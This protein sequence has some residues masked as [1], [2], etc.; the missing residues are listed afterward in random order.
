MQQYQ[1]LKYNNNIQIFTDG[2]K[3]PDTGKSGAAVYIPHFQ[4]SILKRTSDHLTVYTLKCL[5]NIMALSWIEVGPNQYIICSDSMAS[6]Q[7]IANCKS[8]CRPDRIFEI[9]QNLYRLQNNN[10]KVYFLWVPSHVEIECN[11]AA[12][13]LA[14]RALKKGTMDSPAEKIQNLK[15]YK[16]RSRQIMANTVG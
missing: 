8:V 10:I 6:L 9:H 11:E 4:K 13:R 14:K 3:D 7:S 15:Y 2:L 5:A 16:N 12:D 1:G